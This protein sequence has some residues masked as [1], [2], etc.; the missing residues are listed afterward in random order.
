MDGIMTDLAAFTA[1]LAGSMGLGGGFVLMIF[2]SRAGIA[3]DEARAANLLFFIPTALTAMLINHRT[4]GS[5]GAALPYAAAA[6]SIGAV[7]G[8]MIADYADS[9]VL[10]LVF[11]ALMTAVGIKELFHRKEE[12]QGIRKQALQT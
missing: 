6:G 3:P 1:G 12:K 9:G 2:M 7:I 5:D 10:R 11:A 8:L 4:I